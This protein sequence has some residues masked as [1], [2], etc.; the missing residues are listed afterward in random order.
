MERSEIRVGI[1][2][3]RSFPEFAALDPGYLLPTGRLEAN[4]RMTR[5]KYSRQRQ[6]VEGR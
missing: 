6:L 4:V 1:D 3:A 5:A 2:A